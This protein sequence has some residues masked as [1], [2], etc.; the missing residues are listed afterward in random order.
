[1]AV[2]GVLSDSRLDS[3][4]LTC[5]SSQAAISDTRSWSVLS[6]L[7]RFRDLSKVSS[8]SLLEPT[9]VGDP[10]SGPLVYSFVDQKVVAK[11]WRLNPLMKI[12]SFSQAGPLTVGYRTGSK[13]RNRR[14]PL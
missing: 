5:L 14:H 6:P 1:M 12:R 3:R 10:L 9:V 13:V 7:S 2:T 11:A 4:S 8:F